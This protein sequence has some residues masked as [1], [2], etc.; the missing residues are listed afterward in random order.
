MKK[1]L[2]ALLCF[3]SI[4]LMVFSAPAMAA[5]K[6]VD[7]Y[8]NGTKQA[9]QGMV[10]NQRTLLP[11]RDMC[12]IFDVKIDYL[13]NATKQIKVYVD[14]DVYMFTVG[15]K[16]VTCNG[17]AVTSLDT[18][19]V[20]YQYHTYLPARYISD[21][22]GAEINWNTKTRCVELFVDEFVVEN[23]VLEEY[24]GNATKIDLSKR[25]DIKEIGEKVFWNADLTEVKLPNGLQK[26]G[27][28]AFYG[29][30]F[31]EIDI[32]NSVSVIDGWAFNNC[33]NLQRIHLPD[34]LVKI[35][36]EAFCYTNIKELVVPAKVTTIG[37][38]IFRLNYLA[39]GTPIEAIVLP[40]G[41]TNISEHAFN[42]CEDLVIIGLKD[43]YAET[44]ANEH[45]FIFNAISE[46]ELVEKLE[47]R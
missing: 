16:A 28:G 46:K 3:C 18:T 12:N 4:M 34:N 44:Y 27:Y 2:I 31:V 43:S 33:R 39:D 42:Y 17:K 37:S 14:N 8:L 47:I 25:T 5:E 21:L 26:I 23:G 15:S 24:N 1:R 40:P 7:V 41:V 45:G 10:N 19:P 38:E 11:L 30:E 29:N 35:E 22:V 20:I 9:T 6:W 36:N 32:P 13:G